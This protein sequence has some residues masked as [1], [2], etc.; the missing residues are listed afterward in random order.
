[1]YNTDQHD[2][3]CELSSLYNTDCHDFCRRV[4]ISVSYRSV[5]YRDDNPHTKTCRSVLY[6]YR[7]TNPHT[8]VVTICVI[9]RSQLTYKVVV[10]CHLYYTERHDFVCGLAHLYNTDRHD[11]VCGLSSLCNTD[12]HDVVCGICVIQRYQPT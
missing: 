5:L 8:K 3:V 11:F 12:R 7:D 2:F 6:R 9:Q 10:G 4:G 1:V